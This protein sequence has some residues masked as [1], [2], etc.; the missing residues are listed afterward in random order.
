MIFGILISI[1]LLASMI[2]SFFAIKYDW[3][4]AKLFGVSDI[5]DSHKQK[6][7]GHTR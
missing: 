5:S 4:I 2:L 7:P 1:A 3:D 6:K